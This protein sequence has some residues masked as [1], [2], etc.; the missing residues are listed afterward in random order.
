MRQNL[1]LPLQVQWRGISAHTAK[2][3][4]TSV[5]SVDMNMQT[6]RGCEIICTS[7]QIINLLSVN[8]AVIHVEGRI[9]LVT[10]F[11]VL[12]YFISSTI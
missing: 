6:R 12:I 8:Y 3:N 11:K 7:T 5:R 1:V 9:F 10:Y 2:P 4:H